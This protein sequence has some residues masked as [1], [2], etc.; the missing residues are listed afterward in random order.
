MQHFLPLVPVLVIEATGRCPDAQL[1]EALIVLE[2]LAETSVPL[3][4]G[5]DE[6]LDEGGEGLRLQRLLDCLVGGRFEI[7]EDDFGDGLLGGILDR[8]GQAC[9][10]LLLLG[11]GLGDLSFCREDLLVGG[12]DLAISLRLVPLSLGLGLLQLDV[13]VGDHLVGD[14]HLRQAGLGH[15][16]HRPCHLGLQVLAL[17]I[18]RHVCCASLLQLVV[19]SLELCGA[20]INC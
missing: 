10:G 6:G 1:Q 18:G 4:L 19:G 13:G 17:L 16:R 2:V 9:L 7:S 15:V 11:F 3:V 8:S 5:V 14:G 12:V 20:G